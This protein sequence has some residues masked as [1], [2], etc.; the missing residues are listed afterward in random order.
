M[1]KTLI[2]HLLFF[3][4]LFGNTNPFDDCV[5]FTSKLDRDKYFIG[6]NLYLTLDVNIKDGYHIYST[7]PEKS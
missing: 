5:N 1:I 2:S 7:N 4:F 6:E 3:T